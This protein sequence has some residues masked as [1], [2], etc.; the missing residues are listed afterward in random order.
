MVEKIMAH[1]EIVAHPVGIVEKKYGISFVIYRNHE[2]N[3][4][5]NIADDFSN[6]F[7]EL[8]NNMSYASFVRNLLKVCNEFV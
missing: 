3:F 6:F 4:S 2:M 8:K 7:V 5:E 1:A